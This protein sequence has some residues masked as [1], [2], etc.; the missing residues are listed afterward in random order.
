MAFNNAIDANTQGT[1]YLSTAGVWTGID[2]STAT[3][4]LTSNGTGVAPS[5]QAAPASSI[6]LDGNTGSAKGSTISIF[7]SAYGLDTPGNAGT[8]IFTGD[9]S[10][11]LYLSFEDANRNLGLGYH[12]LQL[13]GTANS[14]TMVGY[15]AGQ[16]VTGN[17][18]TGFGTSACGDISSGVGNTAV[19]Y[20]TLASSNSSYCTAI[21]YTA[22]GGNPGTYNTTLGVPTNSGGVAQGSGQSLGNN[23]TGNICI[24]NIGSSTD[25]NTIRI[26]NQ[27]TAAGQQNVCYIAGITGT[28]PTSANTPQVMVCDSS[29]NLSVLSSSTSGYVLTS[30]GTATPTFQVNPGASGFNNVVIQTFTASGT[31]TPTTGMLYAV[32]EVQGGGGAGGGASG[33]TVGVGSG[34]GGGGYSMGVFSAASVS[35]SQVINIGSAGAGVSNGTGGAGGS[36]SVGALI[37]A[38]GGSGGI[39]NNGTGTTYSTGGTGGSGSGGTI[40]ITGSTGGTSSNVGTG[41]TITSGDGATTRFGNGGFGIA[42]V[43]GSGLTATAQAATG[44]GCGGG[45]AFTSSGNKAG[46]AGGAGIINIWEYI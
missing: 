18:N 1:Q 42:G 22:S 19:G 37:T 43:N 27:G 46:G 41:L 13:V 4:L 28:T 44:Y 7:T 14:N 5:F 38:T 34:G 25:N 35:T 10:T 31:Y 12:A 45:G 39:V 30:N 6:T 8:A 23:A 16:P 36:S 20:N 32:I 9:G 2:A 11:S 21:G 26:G 33:S 40:N 3:Y 15:S 29:G 24:S 17:Y